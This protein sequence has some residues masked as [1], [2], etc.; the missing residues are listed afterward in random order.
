MIGEKKTMEKKVVIWICILSL[1]ATLTGCSKSVNKEENIEIKGNYVEHEAI[2][3]E[4]VS[5]ELRFAVTTNTKNQIEYYT[6]QFTDESS[7]TMVNCYTLVDKSYQKSSVGWIENAVHDF[8]FYPMEFCHGEDGNDYVLGFKTDYDPSSDSTEENRISYIIIKKTD[9]EKGYLDVTPSYWSEATKSMEGINGLQIGDIQ[10]TKDQVLCYKINYEEELVFYDL[11]RNKEVDY[12]NYETTQNY[13]IKENT[14]YYIPKDAPEIHIQPLGQEQGK[15]V[16]LESIA[17]KEILQVSSDDSLI[18]LDNKGIHE[19]KNGGTMW[20]TIVDGKQG[21]MS[22]PSYDSAAFLVLPGTYKTYYV[23]YN[24]KVADKEELFAEYTCDENGTNEYV[25]PDNPTEQPKKKLTIYS[26]WDSTT[27][28]QAISQYSKTHP[29]ISFDYVVAKT[30]DSDVTQSDLIRTLNTDILAGN[31]A[32]IFLLDGL[33]LSSYIQKGVLMDMSDIFSKPIQDKTLLNNIANSYITDGKIY[34]MPTRIYMP[35]YV[36]S[37]DLTNYNKTVEDLA[38][39]CKNSDKKLMEEISYRLLVQMFMYTYSNEIFTEDGLI[40]KDNLLS[41]LTSMDE[42]SKQIGAKKEGNYGTN[43]GDSGIKGANDRMSEILCGAAYCILLDDTDCSVTF[44]GD[45]PDLSLANYCSK[46]LY[47]PMNESFVPNGMIGINKMTEQPELAKE[48][49]SYLFCEEMQSLHLNDG[50]P[51][52]EKALSSWMNT[53]EYDDSICSFKAQ[54]SEG[55]EMEAT[56]GPI[57]VEEKQKAA[58]MLK[59]LTRPVYT[60]FIAMDMILTGAE[61]YLAGEKSLDEA[62]SQINEKVNLYLGE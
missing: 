20:E 11:V 55:K 13:V 34:C 7:K 62:V 6:I 21:S 8:N 12:G 56:F 42:I 51:V 47:A 46:G 37:K 48:F 10:I 9:D 1:I 57:T 50:F 39:Y 24:S 17:E 45:I 58:D 38:A 5:G 15:K 31:G 2:R 54:N 23:L 29:E 61:E 22:V 33:P 44:I 59:T 53:P 18:L 52:N 14:L 27:I 40:N 41:F 3:P 25:A 28:R 43:S 16:E 49:V 35:I 30:E 60:D 4:I 26:M 19:L 36:M 32:D